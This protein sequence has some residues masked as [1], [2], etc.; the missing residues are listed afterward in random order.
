MLILLVLCYQ[1]ATS[2][3]ISFIPAHVYFEGCKVPRSAE[4]PFGKNVLQI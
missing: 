1:S 2:Y 4:F 3:F